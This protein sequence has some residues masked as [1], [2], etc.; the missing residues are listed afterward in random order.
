MLHSVPLQ[1][2]C[3][4]VMRTWRGVK[5]AVLAQLSNGPARLAQDVTCSW[6]LTAAQHY[7]EHGS[8]GMMELSVGTITCARSA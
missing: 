1:T 3:I 7:G 5:A 2:D 4:H 8:Q 6:L